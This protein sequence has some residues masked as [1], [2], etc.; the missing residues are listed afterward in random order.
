MRKLEISL[1]ITF[2]IA[3]IMFL[4]LFPGG[5]ALIFLS[6][7]M[8]SLFYFFL[9]IPFLNRLKITDCFSKKI[10]DISRKD[11]ILSLYA[12]IILSLSVLN[13]LFRFMF[14]EGQFF[15]A[16]S[17][18]LFSGVLL[19][20]I[21]LKFRFKETIY[22]AVLIRTIFAFIVSLGLFFVST[23]SIVK[24]QFRNYPKYLDVYGKFIANPEDTSLFKQLEYERKLI[25]LGID[26]NETPVE[27]FKN[28][29]IKVSKNSESVY[30]FY[31]PNGR[32]SEIGKIFNS[33]KVELWHEY[34]QDG[35]IKWIGNYINNKRE[36]VLRD[37][38]VIISVLNDS[39]AM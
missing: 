24:I 12:G 33:K 36:V 38:T 31:Y 23:E 25:E 20:L 14:W 28:G 19:L 10:L 1:L 21:L 15:L 6:L 11:L 8:L 2:S 37:T 7:S 16:H 17:S 29:A 4:M 27:I 13:V 34:Y 32:R 18:L 39:K 3:F 30:T 5:I 9:S 35:S 22:K 26:N